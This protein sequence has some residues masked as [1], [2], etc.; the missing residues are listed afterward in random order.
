MVEL[1]ETALAHHEMISE[2][3]GMGTAHQERMRL[4][5]EEEDVVDLELE[6]I[7][8]VVQLLVM[9]QW[10]NGVEE[11]RYRRMGVEI[12]VADMA[13]AAEGEEEGTEEKSCREE[14]I[15]SCGRVDDR[16]FQIATSFEL[17]SSRTRTSHF[18]QH[19]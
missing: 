19:L 6:V 9:C 16:V 3:V 12:G 1:H 4:E 15:R 13:G 8:D 5:A 2:E 14:S 18:C 11:S 7:L 10:E 17:H